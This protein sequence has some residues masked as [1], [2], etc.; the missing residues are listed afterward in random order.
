M[1]SFL[2]GA[3]DDTEGVVESVVVVEDAVGDEGEAVW[4]LL[5]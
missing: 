4:L 2:A 5:L 3:D 1:V